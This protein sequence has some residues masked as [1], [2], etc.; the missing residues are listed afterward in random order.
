VLYRLCKLLAEHWGRDR[1]PAQEKF[2]RPA[3]LVAR[4]LDAIPSRLTAAGFAIV[5]DFEDAI[6]CWRA[7][8]PQWPDRVDGVV[9]ASGAGAMGVRL[10]MPVHREDGEFEDR[11]ELGM[12]NEADADYLDTTIGL[13]WR[14]LILWL[15]V[16]L[17][18]TI[19]VA[20]A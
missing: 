11:P 4:A 15:A 19:V 14:A 2:S 5:G 10:G 12:G 18:A 7:Q 3:Q 9:L 20:L 6:F 1:S 17:V 13:L 8:A 16:I